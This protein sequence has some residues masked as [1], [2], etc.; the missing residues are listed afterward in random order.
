MASAG[1]GQRGER[2][3]VA[4]HQRWRAGAQVLNWGE[5]TF[6]A[7]GLNSFNPVDVSRRRVPGSEVRE[8][9][10][11][12]PMVQASL[13]V[14]DSLS[15]EAFYQLRWEPTVIDPPGSYFSNNDFVGA[16]GEKVWLGFGAIGETSPFGAIPR[17][18]DTLPEDG[19][20]F[21][22][23]ARYHAAALNDTEFGL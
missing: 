9:L 12:V 6:I 2:R 15:L 23:A 18:P 7:Q 16:G 8:A 10:K 5:S 21:G 4:P 17:G 1:R 14:N 22:L 19:G 11:A 3:E 20:Q 13:V